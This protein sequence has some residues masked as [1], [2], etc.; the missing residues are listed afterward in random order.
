MPCLSFSQ[1]LFLFVTLHQSKIFDPRF[2]V[3]ETFFSEYV[4]VWCLSMDPYL[5]Y[6]LTS[7]VLSFSLCQNLKRLKYLTSNGKWLSKVKPFWLKRLYQYLESV[8]WYANFSIKIKFLYVSRPNNKQNQICFKYELKDNY[9]WKS[10]P[11]KYNIWNKLRD[12]SMHVLLLMTIN[13][14]VSYL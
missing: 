10:W 12:N 13:D 7:L 8:G 6:L 9:S 5:I 11:M 1:Q 2:S 3:T 14:P 4:G